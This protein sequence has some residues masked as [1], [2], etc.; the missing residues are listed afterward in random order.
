MHTVGDDVGRRRPVPVERRPA[1][2]RPEQA[3]HVPGRTGRPG[4]TGR[5]RPRSLRRRCFGRERAGPEPFVRG[6]FVQERFGRGRFGRER[7][8]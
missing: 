4:T 2:R 3:E 8:G 1:G 5:R 7:F 6:R